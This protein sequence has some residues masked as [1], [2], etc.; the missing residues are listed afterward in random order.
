MEPEPTVTLVQ[1][2][3]RISLTKDLTTN[4]G[5]LHLELK[6]EPTVMLV[7]VPTDISDKGFDNKHRSF[8]PGA[9][10]GADCNAGS[11]AYGYL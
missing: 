8:T 6:L 5:L 7:A 9:L 4:T 2:C 11:N 1:Q 10:A 3:L